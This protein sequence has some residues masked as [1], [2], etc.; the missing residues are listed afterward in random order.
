MARETL[1]VALELVF[2]DEGDYSNVKTDRG[3]P[4]KYGV[5]HT[6]LAAHRGVRSATAD[7]VT[8][9]SRE[10]AENSLGVVKQAVTQSRSSHQLG[11][12]LIAFIVQ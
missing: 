1:P 2:G 11:P 10:G 12:A 3:G 9:L 7:Q 6:T 8:A 4:T 5:T